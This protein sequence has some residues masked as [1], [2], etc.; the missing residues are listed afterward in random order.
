MEW[1]NNHD[2]HLVREVLAV[3]PYQHKAGTR[4][5]GAAWEDIAGNLRQVKSIRFHVTQRS[6]RDRFRLLMS[7]FK[8]SQNKEM[9]QSGINPE[10]TEVEVAL[11]E[12]AEK[13]SVHNENHQAMT[14]T[15]KDQVEKE[16]K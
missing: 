7:R 10:P 6:V 8:I 5:S 3:E 15:K 13:I 14:Q 2:C 4:E 16:K 12:I 9:A 11:E 1:T